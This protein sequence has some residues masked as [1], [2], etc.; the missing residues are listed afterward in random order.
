MTYSNFKKAIAESADLQ[1]FL[2]QNAVVP[3]HFHVTEVGL[4]SKKFIDCGG[5]LHEEKMV[6]VQF[7]VDEKDL[8]HR[9]TPTRFSKILTM[10]ES[11]L[12]NQDLEVEI[13]FQTSTLGKYLVEKKGD[14]FQ[15]LPKM[16]AC[17]A[18]ETCGI[19]QKTG[20]FELSLT[21]NS[22]CCTPGGGCC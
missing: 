10:S 2:P 1:F 14:Y 7:W 4:S 16:T 17:L 18:Q 3:P 20:F 13:E 21:E 12:E 22:S 6:S 5:K 11:V 19:P 8:D 9:L 15:L